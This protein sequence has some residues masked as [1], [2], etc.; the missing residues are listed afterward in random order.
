[1]VGIFAAVK[2]ISKK[3][4]NTQTLQVFNSVNDAA[5]SIGVTKSYLSGMLLGRYKNWTNFK[6]Y[7]NTATD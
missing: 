1:M 6:Y 5:K 2:K 7:E 3:V 4:I